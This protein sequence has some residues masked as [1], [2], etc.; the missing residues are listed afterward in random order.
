MSCKG[1]GPRWPLFCFFGGAYASGVTMAAGLPLNK[2]TGTTQMA[3][4][5]ETAFLPFLKKNSMGVLT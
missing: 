4:G 3:Q 5:V 1:K 2:P